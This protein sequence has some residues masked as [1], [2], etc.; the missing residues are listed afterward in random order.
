MAKYMKRNKWPLFPRVL[1]RIRTTAGWW[2]SHVPFGA[3]DAIPTIQFKRRH[4]CIHGCSYRRITITWASNLSGTPIMLE[5]KRGYIL[6]GKRYFATLR[7]VVGTKRCEDHV[8][9]PNG[10]LF[11]PASWI[12]AVCNDESWWSLFLPAPNN[13]LL[14]GASDALLAAI[15]KTRPVFVPSQTLGAK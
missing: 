8:L 14:A 10:H 4:P 11:E 7:A 9:V 2:D 13:H 6:G 1:D 12:M 3:D 5:E 15:I